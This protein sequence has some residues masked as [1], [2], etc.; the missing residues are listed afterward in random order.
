MI[1]LRQV[2]FEIFLQLLSQVTRQY[3]F[4]TKLKFDILSR[5][6][7]EKKETRNWE[8]TNW[9][10]DLSFLLEKVGTSPDSNFQVNPL[11]FARIFVMVDDI[12]LY[13]AVSC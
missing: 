7:R 5:R 8:K 3:Q 12:I 13:P 6:E 10:V 11:Q 9:K 4:S 1:K 2:F